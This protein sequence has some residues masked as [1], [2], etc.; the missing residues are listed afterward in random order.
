MGFLFGFYTSNVTS[1]QSSTQEESSTQDTEEGNEQW[2][3][4]EMPVLVNHSLDYVS[5]RL[6][7]M[8]V[9]CV[10]IGDGDE[11]IAQYPQAQET[12]TSNERIILLSDASTLTMP[13]MKGWTRK[14]VT[15]FWKLTGI[16]I[17]ISG[18]GKVVS[19]SIEAGQA[20]STDSEISV[21]L[22]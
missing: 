10:I 12:I 7:D 13:D 21:K 15:A 8:D 9:E 22:E 5:R 6:E 16:P 3:S 20:V 1:S 18:S 17:S 11:I 4:Y 19:Q 14:D 2:S